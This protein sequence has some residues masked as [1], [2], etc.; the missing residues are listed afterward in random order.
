MMDTSTTTELNK[1]TVAA[2]ANQCLESFNKCLL[3]ES[4]IHPREFSLVED[5]VARFSTWSSGIGVFAPGRASMDH[6]LRYAPEVQSIA[7]SLLESLNYRIQKLL[8]FLHTHANGPEIHTSSVL[9]ERLGKLLGYIATEISHLN[10]MTNIIRKANQDS[11]N[12]QAKDFD[13]TDE[14]GNDVQPILLSHYKRYIGERFPT[15]SVTIQ[16]RLADAMILR[17]KQI[18]YRRSR[19]GGTAIQLP[20]LENKVSNTLPDSLLPLEDTQKA[21]APSRVKSATTLQPEKF[22]M[23][24]SSPSVIS[25][26]M[27]IALG[28]HEALKFPTA[29]G[30]H[31]KRSYEQFKAEQLAAHQAML[32]KAG[33]PTSDTD[34]ALDDAVDM[35]YAKRRLFTE[36]QLSK[37]FKPDVPAIGEVTCPY[38]FYTLSLE[39]VFDERKWQNHVKNDLDPYLCLFEECSEPDELYKHSEKWLSHMHQHIQRW[40]CPSHRELGLFPTC[41]SYMQHVRDVHDTK[42]NDN[43]LRALANRNARSLPKLFLS[44]PLCGKDES[45]INTP[46]ADHITGHLRSLAIMSLPIHYDDNLTGDVGSEKNGSSNSQP[47]SR[48]TINLLDDEDILAIRSAI[49]GNLDDM[50]EPSTAVDTTINNEEDPVDMLFQRDNTQSDLI[51]HS[52]HVRVNEAEVVSPELSDEQKNLQ[53][54]FQLETDSDLDMDSDDT[55]TRNPQQEQAH[56]SQENSDKVTAPPQP[57]QRTKPIFNNFTPLTPQQE[58]SLTPEQRAR[59]EL[60]LK[61]HGKIPISTEAAGDSLN[62]LKLIVKEEQRQFS[63]EQM[64]EIP[65]GPEEYA[66]T[67][68]KLKRIVSDM[69]K[70]GRGLSKWYAI[71]QDDVRAKMFFRTRLRIIKQHVDS[72]QMEEMKDVFSIRSSDLDQARA[73]LESMAKDLAA[74]VIGRHMMRPYESQRGGQSAPIDQTEEVAAQHRKNTG[75]AKDGASKS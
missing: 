49:D 16:Q 25:A 75:K 10:K 15:A 13:M 52:E 63:Q 38:C 60:I 4:F 56:A 50:A 46:L 64:V 58:A 57:I 69:G 22:K 47:Q 31:A 42:I 54:N 20:K 27:T 14:E 17:R 1:K 36:Q 8:E 7:I 30:L 33:E 74:S 23:A 18:L 53:S 44:C 32:G 12:V 61:N 39:E 35:R 59:Y 62:R 29:P 26:T 28:N 43:K 71:T 41:E 11:Q 5:Q 70:V 73:L 48:S 66:E 19:Y 68:Q 34:R 45:E 21:A 65:M 3:Q 6:R 2:A 24:A 67:A 51:P 40:R 9:D 55:D 37:V 72:E